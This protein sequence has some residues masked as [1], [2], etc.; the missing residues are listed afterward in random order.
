MN[1]IYGSDL[2]SFFS[3]YESTINGIVGICAVLGFL[4]SIISG[5]I[6]LFARKKVKESE[7]KVQNAQEKIRQCEITTDNLK[8][9]NAQ[10]VQIINNYGLSLEETKVAA[11]DVFNEKAKNKPDIYLGEQE[12]EE[13]S[14]N[15]IWPTGV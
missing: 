12:P 1:M 10:I 15:M 11:E 6:G 4:G 2:N 5:V 9:Q 3:T 7:D 14:D 8:M 13:L